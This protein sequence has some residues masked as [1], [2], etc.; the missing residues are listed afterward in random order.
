MSARTQSAAA[1]RRKVDALTAKLRAQETA[2]MYGGPDAWRA[3]V[4]AYPC[5]RAVESSARKHGR[6]LGPTFEA[7]LA[8][9]LECVDEREDGTRP[10][11]ETAASLVAMWSAA[12]PRPAVAQ[13]AKV[14]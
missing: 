8:A 9:R 4:A 5:R 11:P 7:L 10:T 6:M 13:K 14:A 2:W 12:G 1:L 3:H